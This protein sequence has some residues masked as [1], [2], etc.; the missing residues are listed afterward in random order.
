MAEPVWRGHLRLS[1]VSCAVS[2]APATR[3]APTIRL[4]PLNGRTGNPVIEQLVDARTGDIVPAEVVIRGYKMP[5][6]SHATIGNPELAALGGEPEVIDV[7]HFCRPGDIDRSRF[8]VGYYLYPDGPLAADT[9]ASL[10]LAMQ[11]EW[12]DAIAYLRLGEHERMALIGVH[13]SGLLLTT[14]RP[15][16][17]SE[18]AQFV[19]RPDD[20][21]PADMIETAKGL[22]SRRML[23][24]ATRLADRYEDR[25]RALIAKKTGVPWPEP[26]EEGVVGSA[27]DDPTAAP[28]ELTVPGRELGAEILLHIVDLGDRRFVEPGWTGEP[29]S[30][31]Q[32]EAISIRPRDEASP[33]AIEYQVFARD[34]RATAWVGNGSYAG[35]RDR[36]LPLTGFAVRPAPEWRDRLDVVYEGRFADG[37][38]VGP[39]M[40][41]EACVSP[42]D[43]DPLEALRISIVARADAAADTAA[44]S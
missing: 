4:D 5:D 29:G 24:D 33:E 35:T 7:A 28:P 39:K 2:L 34:G 40:N 15:A 31:R 19:E 6:G 20:E 13:D 11:R 17:I 30:R 42:I 18:P 43:G 12:V 27:A 3:E 23:D 32:I 26:E 8:D 9:L 1:L 10:R 14:L 44:S 41:G 21:I 16:A 25:L 36:Q 37:G 38:V 22:I